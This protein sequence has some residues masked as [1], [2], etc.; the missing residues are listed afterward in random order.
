MYQELGFSLK[1]PAWLKK[2]AGSVVHGTTATIPT[3]TGVPITVDLGNPASVDAA[4]RALAGTKLSTRVGQSG[5]TL[6]QQADAAVTGTVPGGWLTLIG[7]GLA[8][9]LFLRG[10][11]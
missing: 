7:A 6:A 1:P 3:P 2:I 4:K 8:A 10:R 11:R 9:M 5:P